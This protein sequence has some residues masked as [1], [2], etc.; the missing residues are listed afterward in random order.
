[1]TRSLPH[2]EWNGR[3]MEAEEGATPGPKMSTWQ[4]WANE[5]PGT[6]IIQ[7]RSVYVHV[8]VALVGILHTKREGCQH[9]AL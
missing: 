8:G 3:A 2:G 4:G 1:M 7:K 6:H 5:A 9:R